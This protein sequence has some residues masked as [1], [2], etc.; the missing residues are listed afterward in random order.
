MRASRNIFN[1]QFR[2]FFRFSV[3]RIVVKLSQLVK[4]TVLILALFVV[5]ETFYENENMK[6]QVIPQ[7]YTYK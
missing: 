2:N 7:N 3:L 5:V 1:I 4:I 6:L